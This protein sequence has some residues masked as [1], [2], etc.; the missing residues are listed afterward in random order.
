M[1]FVN[2]SHLMRKATITILKTAYTYTFTQ[3]LISTISHLLLNINIK[4]ASTQENL[5]SGICEQQKRRPAFASA[6]SDQRLCF[7][8]IEKYHTLTCYERNFN[9]LASLCGGP[10][11]FESHVVGNPKDWFS[12]VL[13][14]I[15]I[16]S[17]QYNI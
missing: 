15:V 6:Q 13:A 17:F 2:I 9:F 12:H 16:Q 14:Q 1:L 4:W 10:A 11:W 3:S 5:S 8:L 7:S